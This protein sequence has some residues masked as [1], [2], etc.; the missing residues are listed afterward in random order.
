MCVD[1]S[2]S[3]RRTQVRIYLVYILYIC[4][5]CTV[6]RPSVASPRVPG[7]SRATVFY[8]RCIIQTLAHCASHPRRLYLPADVCLPV[9]SSSVAINQ[10]ARRVGC[11]LAP[12]PQLYTNRRSALCQLWHTL[13]CLLD[14]KHFP[15][16]TLYAF[17]RAATINFSLN[18][19]KIAKFSVEAVS[20]Q[21]SMISMTNQDSSST[22]DG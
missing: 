8:D 4:M 21:F 3:T 6:P 5:Y 10:P 18:M 7:N 2:T 1:R 19:V 14:E 22:V 20:L 17:L 16:T 13:K 12:P 15:S 11:T 9:H